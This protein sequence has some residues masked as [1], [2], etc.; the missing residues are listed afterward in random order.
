MPLYIHPNAVS[1]DSWKVVEGYPALDTAMWGWAPRTGGHA[2]RLILGGVFDHYPNAQV[3]LGHMGEFLP[4]QLSRLDSRY[5]VLD[6][7]HPLERLPSEYFGT[8]IAITTTGVFS[9]AALIAAIQDVGIDNVMFSI[10]YPFESTKQA[11]RVHPNR[12]VGPR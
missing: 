9:H 11:V 10:D 2:V 6:F 4:F 3:I 1:S 8:N 5:K 12:A 7:E